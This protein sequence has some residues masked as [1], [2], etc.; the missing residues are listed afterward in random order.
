MVCVISR[1]PNRLRP[2]ALSNPRPSSRVS[3][4]IQT[5]ATLGGNLCNGS[6]AADTAPPLLVLD[7]EVDRASV[8]ASDSVIAVVDSSKIGRKGLASVVPITDL[9]VLITDTGAPAEFT[10]QARALGLDVRLV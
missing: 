7:A 8:R 10:A 4:A 3:P 2:T 1:L 9:D 6:P 5:R